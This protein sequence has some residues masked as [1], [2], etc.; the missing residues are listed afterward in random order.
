QPVA[1]AEPAA[2]AAVGK[3]HDPL[4][5]RRQAQVGSNGL[6]AGRDT[7]GSGAR[8]SGRHLDLLS[9]RGGTLLLSA[10]ETAPSPPTANWGKGA[11]HSRAWA[12]P[13]AAWSGKPRPQPL[14]STTFRGRYGSARRL[15]TRGDGTLGA[16]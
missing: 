2:A 5:L 15:V 14:P 12:A 8:L 11:A 7:D 16:P 9:S 10:L 13:A 4:S 6:V 1:R 3:Q